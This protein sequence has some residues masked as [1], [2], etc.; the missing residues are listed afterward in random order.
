MAL[1]PVY[2]VRPDLAQ[3]PKSPQP[4]APGEKSWLC[5][6][7]QQICRSKTG[8]GVTWYKKTYPCLHYHYNSEMGII[9]NCPFKSIPTPAIKNRL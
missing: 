9:T 3:T 5:L 7:S 8:C 2:H 6:N 4:I 1:D